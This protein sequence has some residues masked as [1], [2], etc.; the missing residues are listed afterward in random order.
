MTMSA[1]QRFTRRRCS[2]FQFASTAML[3]CVVAAVLGCGGTSTASNTGAPAP[4]P[5]P[6]PTTGP[7][8]TLIGL[9]TQ[10]P[11]T[12]LTPP[13][14]DFAEL[15]AHP[16]VYSAAV[17]QLYWSQ[18][19]PSQGVFDDSA[20]TSALASLAA[21][22]TRY[23]STPVV[24]K[25]RI[26]MGLGTPAWVAQATG[27]ITVSNGT[28]SA[29]VGEYWST[30]YNVLWKALQDHLAS[31]YDTDSRIGEVAITSCS[32][33]TGEP[34]IMTLN[35]AN[36]ALLHQAGYTDAQ[37]IACLSNAAND[38][39]GWTHTPLDYTFNAFTHTDSTP[40]VTDTDFPIQVM[41]AF[42]SALGTRAV[43]ANHGLQDPLT[44]AA[45]P[46]YNEFQTLGTQASAAGTTSS[47]EFQTAGPTVDWDST[48][49]YALT[50][51]P[52]EIE[53]WNT[54]A[55]G[56]QAPLSQ[57]QLAAYATSLKQQSP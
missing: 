33:L 23:P 46:I 31:E 49:A 8:P 19:E 6:S 24:A 21:Y 48:I 50:Y 22:N 25:L 27:P 17:V 5:P 29:T 40:Y 42:R 45:T 32:S 3:F 52:T 54:V 20:L 53:I 13:T 34:F 43:V 2:L 9:V 57:A 55:A 26:F 11:G 15:N 47:L 51:H 14:N 1:V 56:G 7:K 30:A 4:A 16:G 38:Y 35:S 28:Q 39:S 37:Q 44:A 12:T 10:G 41:T 18:L 36:V